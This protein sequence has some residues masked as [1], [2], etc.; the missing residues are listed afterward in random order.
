MQADSGAEITEGNRHMK[1]IKT[2]SSKRIRTTWSHFS[3]EVSRFVTEMVHV[4][5]QKNRHFLTFVTVCDTKVSQVLTKTKKY[6]YI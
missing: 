6:K 4:L 3:R 5:S 2:D 1:W